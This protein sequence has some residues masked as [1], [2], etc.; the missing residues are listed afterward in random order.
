MTPPIGFLEETA[1]V[2]S[3][4][5]LVVLLMAIGVLALTC[6]LAAYLLV[7]DAPD[8]GVIIAAAGPL[9]ALAA[10]LWKALQERSGGES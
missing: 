3:M 8:A 9:G 2:R 5:R 6:S 7:A 1:G 10:G 4:T